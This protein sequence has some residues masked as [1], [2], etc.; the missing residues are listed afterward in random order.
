VLE[1][2]GLPK[3]AVYLWRGGGFAVRTELVGTPAILVGSTLASD[4]TDRQR[5]FLVARAAELYRTGHTLAEKLSAPELGGVAAALCLAVDPNCNPPG[6][7]MD[8]PVWANT[9]AAPMTEA[10]RNSLKANVGAY[11]S[12]QSDVD[13]SSWR[14]GALLTAGRVAMLLSADV[15]EAVSALLRLRGMDDLTDDQRVAVIR[16]SPEAMDLMRFACT[17]HYYKLR[18]AL[19]LALRRSK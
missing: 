9:I 19:G 2:L 8:T 12:A 16:E 13:F 11:L 4:A 14:W 15:E 3:V 18:Q 10:I 5:A 1:P 17:E 7:T 6:G